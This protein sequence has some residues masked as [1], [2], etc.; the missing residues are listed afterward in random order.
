[1]PPDSVIGSQVGARVSAPELASVIAGA[2]VEAAAHPLQV[3]VIIIIIII[4][5]ILSIIIITCRGLTPSTRDRDS[6]SS[7]GKVCPRDTLRCHSPRR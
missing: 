7:P 5:I 3:A 2:G 1:M 4:I 6:Q